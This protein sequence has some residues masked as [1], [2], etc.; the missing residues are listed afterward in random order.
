MKKII[1][2]SIILLLASFCLRA[3]VTMLTGHHTAA[4]GTQLIVPVRAVDFINIVSAQGT[5]QFDPSILTFVSVQDFGFTSLSA[6]N[7]GTSQTSTGKLMFM[8]T[9]PDLG[10]ES[11]PD[12]AVLFTIRF[13]IIGTSGQ[14]SALTF[15]NLPTAMEVINN[16]FNPETLNLITGSVTIQNIVQAP[17]VTLKFDSVSGIHGSQLLISCRA[18]NFSNINSAQGT[19]VFDHSVLAFDG[20]GFCGLPGLNA[21]SF[22]LSQLSQGRITF[23]WTDSELLGQDLADG[24]ALFSL[25][26]LLTGSAG[27][28]SEIAFTDTP[29]PVEV[30]DSSLT[31]LPAG[32]VNGNIAI[33]GASEVFEIKIDSVTASPGFQVLVPVRAWH[34][35][36]IISL[37]GTITFD[38][39]HAAFV[40]IEQYGLPGMD[41]TNFGTTLT[42]QGKLM[43]M[44]TDAAASGQ[45]LNDSSVLFAIKFS[46]TASLGSSPY[47]DFSNTPTPIEITDTS[48][49]E[50][51]FN[52]H[53]GK[54]SVLG[55]GYKLSGKTK[56]GARAYA[57]NPVPSMPTYGSV[58]YNIS[59]VIVRLKS[60]PG[61]MELARDT[62]NTY[63]TYGF[64]NVPDGTYLL[65]YDKYTA[66][67]MQMGNEINAIDVAF[68]KY[69]VGHDTLQDPSRNFSK[70]HKKAADV[71]NNSLFNALDIARL[72][73]KVGQPYFA[74]ANFSKGNWPA[75][76]TLVT[77]AGHDL[78][79]NLT[80]IGYGDYDAS[81]T[82]Y[83]DSA[84]NWNLAKSSD[85][86]AIIY[87]STDMLTVN[88]GAFFEVPLSILSKINEFSAMGL[89]LNYP[90]T[91]FKLVSA[92]I[93][94]GNKKTVA[95]K[96]N[97][98][99]EEIVAANNDLLVTDADGVIRVVYATT[100]FFDVAAG[101]E[102]LVLGF[103]PVREMPQGETEFYLDGTGLVADQYGRENENAV[104]SMPKIFFQG[105]YEEKK[106]EFSGF[107]NPMNGHTVL[108]FE[109]S[110]NANVKLTLYNARGEKIDELLNKPLAG[111]AYSIPYCSIH[112]PS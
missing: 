110:E 60:Y 83:K 105:N 48:H 12:S 23:S 52:T 102:I 58:K 65:S 1:A 18:Y 59:Q 67:T 4:E 76:D 21:S 30:S 97:P 51:S 44:W 93:P 54:I 10:G 46:V 75:A 90:S 57:G 100:D 9:D 16:S 108:T 27:Q 15:V 22:G 20:V 11:L 80:T 39:S 50:I 92:S 74:T 19:I 82:K 103:K 37:Q 61:G 109:T 73:A 35:N 112:L 101:D 34:F 94:R 63:G 85:A 89:E 104:L 55:G 33:T 70:R 29:T 96:I 43:F 87:Q 13:N 99:F 81:S 41:S 86:T 49:G 14:F 17:A 79:V 107:P 98:S 71:D 69:L 3:N 40:S 26:F 5:L 62:S 24:D 111:G 66:D 42:N 106:L 38:P 56:Y 78:I 8:W 95:S 91:Y 64:N 31:I 32:T 47:L 53:F 6:G 36:K 2:N 72:K 88:N 7:F 45:N 25:L 68:L 77:I 84:N 28:H